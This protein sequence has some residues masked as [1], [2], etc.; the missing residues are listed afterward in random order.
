MST[1][2][3]AQ[4]AESELLTSY[5]RRIEERDVARRFIDSLMQASFEHV[6][7]GLRV[8]RGIYDIETRSENI[9]IA[10]TNAVIDFWDS[11]IAIV[12]TP[13]QRYRVAAIGTPGIGKTTCTPILIRKLLESNKTVVYRVCTSDKELWYYEFI[14]GADGMI[15]VEVYPEDIYATASL[16]VSS[17]YY[18]ADSGPKKDSCDPETGFRPKVIL[19][20]PPETECWGGRYFTKGYHNDMGYFKHFPLWSLRELVAAQP[21]LRPSMN[22][23]QVAQ[24]YRLFGGVPGRVFA[25]N[26][27]PLLRHQE[28]ALNALSSFE[29][30]ERIAKGWTND[31]DTFAEGVL[32]STLIGFSSYP[33]GYGAFEKGH[34]H[35]LSD[36]VVDSLYSEHAGRLWPII[37]GAGKEAK[38]VM[39]GYVRSLLADSTR[40]SVTFP[41]WLSSKSSMIKKPRFG[42]SVTIPCC[43]EARAVVD[44]ID[45]VTDPDQTPY[46]LF[47]SSEPRN[48]LIDCV[49]K[50]AGG[51][52]YAISITVGKTFRI[53]TE[54]INTFTRAAAQLGLA[55]MLCN[56]VPQENFKS[57]ASQAA[58]NQE[59]LCDIWHLS[60][61][62][63]V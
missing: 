19:I 7:G 32:R 56:L 24:R 48:G 33:N 49:L 42:G 17:T 16:D 1:A 2:L 50:D 28:E 57:F 39:V 18:I 34:S 54:A 12:E 44:I 13:N 4:N 37:L 41:A 45:A 53:N 40:D 55:V 59:G 8:L 6:P 43:K 22:K 27:A 63:P 30:V 31:H 3:T 36:F 62:R 11:C 15:S 38:N 10:V 47:H 14:P 46:V 60:V 58:E 21:I 51:L 20:T 29:D 61:S 23:D 52:V 26:E 25:K 9:T 35:L 5:F